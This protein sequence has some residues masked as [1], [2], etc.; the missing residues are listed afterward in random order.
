ME[1]L[2]QDL[3]Y[4]ARQLLRSP[5]FAAVAVLTLALGI[6]ATTAIFTV[7]NAALLRPLPYESPARLVHLWE[8]SS[9]QDF[10]RME[11]SYP[12]YLDWKEQNTT[13]AGLG[14]YGGAGFTVVAGDTV[15][16]ISATR[17]TANFF[18]VLGVKPI[19][20]RD[21]LPQEDQ[22]GQR[23]VLLTYGYWQRRFAA[24]PDIVGRTLNLNGQ[25]WT[26][27]GV[28]PADFQFPLRGASEAWVTLDMNPD[29]Q[30][31]RSL[32]WLNVVSRLKGGTTRGQAE[33]ELRAIQ[34]RL[35]A[36]YPETNSG[37]SARVVPLR[38]EIIGRVRP[39][40]LVLMAAVTCVLLIACV[41]VANLMLVRATGRRK[42]MA[43]RAALGAGRGRLVIQVL[44]ESLMLALL[45][46]GVGVL[47]AGWGVEV[48]V[49]AVPDSLLRDSLV[50]LRG[51]TVDRAA[52]AFALLTTLATTV[53]FGLVPALAAA[54]VS[55]GESLKESGRLSALAGRSR[56]RQG[57]V[58]SE[59]ALA[60]VLLIGAGLTVQSLDRLLEVKLG[61]DPQNLLTFRLLLPAAKYSQPEQ[62]AGFAQQVRGRLESLPGVAGVTTV[63]NFPL[64]NDGNT[65]V[66]VIEGVTRPPGQEPEA[67]TRIVS[68]N[69]FSTLR[70]PV[71]EGRGF[72]TGD[73]LNGPFAVIVNQELVRRHL[74]QL[75]PLGRRVTFL[76]NGAVATIVGVVGDVRLG[77][78]DVPM[79]PTIYLSDQQVPVNGLGVIVRTANNPTSILPA[80]RSEVQALDPELPLFLV[81]TMDELL[82]GSPAVFERRYLTLLLGALAVSALALA[83]V[84]LYGVMAYGVAQ[85]TQ[86]IG[87]RVALGAQNRHILRLVVGQGMKLAVLGVA[88]GLV[89]ALGL[90]QLLSS[91]LFGISATD[92]ITFAGV[93]LLLAMVA[94][95]ACWVPARRASKVDPMVALRYE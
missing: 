16:R 93:S 22:P 11:A 37:Q 90:T 68:P 75:N 31:R 2:W 27:V 89:G 38:E 71:L 44:T 77:R 91:L 83:V 92:P 28:L 4:G 29:Q 51:L 43:V 1:T 62:V 8:V 21:F 42:E 88:L 59:V 79:R 46:G 60:L 34:H 9:R 33:E 45:A 47:L 66:L 63:T 39:L 95:V 58:V 10:D 53:L 15:E 70:I 86:E 26:I 3:R 30:N 7:F 80:V 61:F 17:V 57:L 54:R 56:L 78:L 49:R 20:G 41:N 72:D 6:G 23:S 35:G 67:S 5:G 50:Y 24:S 12:N 81:S 87:I 36:Q 94:G 73:V 14:G 74:P 48:L 69:Y 32:H 82:A 65:N 18:S 19:L 52:L 40:V 55:P 76:S 25:V 84:G 13:L 85:R 64:T